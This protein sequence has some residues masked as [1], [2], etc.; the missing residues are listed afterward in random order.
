MVGFERVLPRAAL[1]VDRKGL[2]IGIGEDRF[3]ALFDHLAARILGKHG[4][5]GGSCKTG[6]FGFD[7]GGQVFLHQLQLR[8]CVLIRVFLLDGSRFSQGRPENI[9]IS[10]PS[11]DPVID[12]LHASR[13]FR[14]LAI[15][16]LKILELCALIAARR[17]KRCGQ[18]DPLPKRAARLV[19]AARNG[20]RIHARR[21]EQPRGIRL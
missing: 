2:Q 17:V 16:G 1:A 4:P 13:K 21:A 7:A 10:F 20:R 19:I 9:G 6:E 8:Q 12:Q 18:T 15:E 11:Q 3:Q 5:P 14:E